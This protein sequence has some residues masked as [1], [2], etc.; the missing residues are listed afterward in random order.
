MKETIKL[1]NGASLYVEEHGKG[2]AVILIPGWTYTMEVFRRNIPALSEHYRTIAYDPR[3]HGRSPVTAGGNDYLQH[4]DDLCQLMGALNVREATL[5]GWSLGVYDVMAYLERFGF[6][7]VKGLV[8]IDESPRIIQ[9]TPGDWAE[10]SEDEITGLIGAVTSDY[11]SFFRDYMAH[12]FVGEPRASWWI[13]L[14]NTRQLCRRNRRQGCCR[15]LP[16]TI[17]ALRCKGP[18]ER[19]RCCRYSVKIGPRRPGDGSRPTSPM[20]RCLYR[21]DT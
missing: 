15:I 1:S 5:I 10:G 6:A 12:G 20:P 2:P 9:S 11:L 13:A 16:T 21:A 3:S 8:L 17:L 7:A 4:G 19:F 18:T 14:S